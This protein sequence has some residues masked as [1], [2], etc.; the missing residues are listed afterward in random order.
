VKPDLLNAKVC[1]YKDYEKKI[2]G[3][4]TFYLR[5]GWAT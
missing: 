4:F 2:T 5:S 1:A 3:L